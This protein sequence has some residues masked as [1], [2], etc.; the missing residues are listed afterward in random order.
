[1]FG[2]SFTTQFNRACVA[3][4][5]ELS[6]MEHNNYAIVKFLLLAL[7]IFCDSSVTW[8]Q[9]CGSDGQGN[10]N[11]TETIKFMLMVPYADPLNKPSFD[12]YY[13]FQ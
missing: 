7:L 4:P 2:L 3:Y 8:S 12:F 6:T 5:N 9:Y 11:S 10:T 13:D 1:M